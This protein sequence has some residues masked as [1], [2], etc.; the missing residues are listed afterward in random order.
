MRIVDFLF[1]V[2]P[3]NPVLQYR[4]QSLMINYRALYRIYENELIIDVIKLG[5]RG[6]VYK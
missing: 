1:P 4:G 5:S 3:V 6:D 2:N